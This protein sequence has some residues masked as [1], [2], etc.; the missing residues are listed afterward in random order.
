MT[1]QVVVA[2]ADLSAHWAFI[3]VALFDRRGT[4]GTAFYFVF[5]LLCTFLVHILDGIQCRLQT[6]PSIKK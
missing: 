2:L 1:L 5:Y 3:R 4:T 6:L